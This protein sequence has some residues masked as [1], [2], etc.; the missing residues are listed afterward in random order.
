V[1]VTDTLA[2]SA[3]ASMSIV[4]PADCSDTYISVTCTGGPLNTAPITLT[5]G[6]SGSST[7]LLYTMRSSYAGIATNS[8]SSV[9]NT[10]SAT[11][12][13]PGITI[14]PATATVAIIGQTSSGGGGGGSGYYGGGG[15]YKAIKGDMKLEITKLVSLDGTNFIESAA[16][17]SLSVAIPE[18]KTT[19]VYNRVQIKNLGAVSATN[20][21]FRHFFDT[22]KSDITA[23]DP[24]DLIGATANSN[25]YYVIDKIKVGETVEMTYSVL[26]TDRGQNT[27]PA[28]DGLELVSYGSAL[29][30]MQDGLTYLGLGSQTKTYLYAGKIPANADAG[31]TTSGTEPSGTTPATG[32]DAISIKVVADRPVANVGDTVTFTLSVRNLTDQNLTHLFVTHQ[33]DPNAFEVSDTYGALAQA[34][35]IQWKKALLR[36]GET[37]TASFKLKVATSAPV[38]QTVRGITQ[39]LVSEY[40][41]VSPYENSIRIGAAG[42]T[43]QLA[44]TGPSHILGLLMALSILAYLGFGFLR[45]GWYRRQRRL[46]LQT[47]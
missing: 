2:F 36:P 20:I 9:T 18:N 45:N 15:G 47:I 24:T 12:T 41:N 43:M 38:G 10:V 3:G 5:L 26:A 39:V 1:T 29:P 23:E 33:F 4:D 46:A 27:N 7:Q 17:K 34:N 35:T 37:L 8:S 31:Q 22:G 32:T 44:Q 42:Q 30:V 14:A 25:G 16:G 13:T 6:N 21:K 11:T 28:A 40:E 19:R